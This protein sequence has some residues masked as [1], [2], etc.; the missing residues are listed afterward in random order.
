MLVE[1]AACVVDASSDVVVGVISVDVFSS[2]VLAERCDEN[3][4]QFVSIDKET[5]DI[6][7][8]SSTK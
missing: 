5:D 6:P 2:S 1:E 7:V 4:N 3:D 8:L